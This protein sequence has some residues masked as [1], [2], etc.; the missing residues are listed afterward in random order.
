MINVLE[1]GYF[2]FV[3]LKK[4]E[5]LSIPQMLSILLAEKITKVTLNVLEIQCK[6]TELSILK[7]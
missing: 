5:V 4:S 6:V 3:V 7:L 2:F 1:N